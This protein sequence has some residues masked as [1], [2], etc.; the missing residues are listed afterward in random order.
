MC[1]QEYTERL[2][3]L[4]TDGVYFMHR[5]LTGPSKKILVEGA[6]A[7][8][9]DIDFGEHLQVFKYLSWDDGRVVF[10]LFFLLPHINR[11][12]SVQAR[13]LSWHLLTAPLEAYALDSGCLRPM[14]AECTELSKL[15]PPVWV[16]VRFQQN[17][18]T[19][20]KRHKLVFL[21]FKK[22]PSYFLQFLLCVQYGL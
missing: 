18:I 9:L 22:N 17:R 4:V 2:R 12:F 16:L 15:T 7:A 13:I 14:L 5:A 21:C 19:W 11:C 10:C 3:P 20:V 1:S 8:L 6:N